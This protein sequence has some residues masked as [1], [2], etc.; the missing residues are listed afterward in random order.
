MVATKLGV[1][2]TL[3]ELK[4]KANFEDKIY[5]VVDMDMFFAAVA[6]RD[7]PDLK[8]KP[9][10]VGGMSM[11]STTNYVA[12]KFG[13]RSA[14]P[15]FIAVKLCPE[16]IFVSHDSDGYS[17]ASESVMNILREYDPNLRTLSLDEAYLE[18]SHLVSSRQHLNPLQ[19][20]EEIAQDLVDEMRTK[21]KNEVHLTC[22]AGIGPTS[23]I[24]KV[25]SDKNKPDGQYCVDFNYRSALEFVHSLK[26]R[27]IPGIGKVTEKL[28]KA[29]FGIETVADV[30]QRRYEISKLLTPSAA[31]HLLRVSIAVSGSF[32]SFQSDPDGRKS[33]S[34]ER[35]FG[36]LSSY[37]AMCQVLHNISEKLVTD[38]KKENLMGRVLTLKAKQCDYTVK[39]KQ[40]KMNS[41][42]GNDSEVIYNTAILL[43]KS[44]QVKDVRLLGLKVSDFVEE[45]N[46]SCDGSRK[47]QRQVL[48]TN[49][50]TVER[51]PFKCPN[52]HMQMQNINNRSLNDHLDVCLKKAIT[53]TKQADNVI[54]LT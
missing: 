53:S 47:R 9:I 50:E 40:Q 41:L 36:S 43:L 37:S 42:I 45:S 35:T 28:L 38:L 52:C 19:T 14:M 54:D 33:M 6:I 18:I 12:R 21:V 11:I 2:K 25:A 27:K 3:E 32:F 34:V 49:L 23:M 4:A 1:D 16:L 46:V 24:A 8:E 39:N 5:V 13:V 17:K 26:I 22:S 31:E 44:L 51:V 20:K 7:D 30:Y 10:A 29:G 48:L 15:G